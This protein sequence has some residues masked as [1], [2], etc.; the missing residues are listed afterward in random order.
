MQSKAT[1]LYRYVE[2]VGNPDSVSFT[3]NIY[4]YDTKLEVKFKYTD[5]VSGSASTIVGCGASPQIYY[6]GYIYTDGTFRFC[7]RDGTRS[8]S[9]GVADTNIHTT[10]VNDNHTSYWDGVAKQTSAKY[11]FNSVSTVPLRFFRRHNG[12]VGKGQIYYVKVWDNL[13]GDLI[14]D[15]RPCVRTSDGVIGFHDLVTDTFLEP[16]GGTPTMGAYI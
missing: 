15:F 14:G 1:A 7:L 10:I 13:T 2:W 8:S 9:L 12:I 3:T 4:P 16:T 11:V 5:F 6:G